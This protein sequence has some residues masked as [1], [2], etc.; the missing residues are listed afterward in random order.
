MKRQ[1]ETALQCEKKFSTVKCVKKY[2]HPA[3]N[4]LKLFSTSRIY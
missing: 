4:V 3:K 1:I 2:S